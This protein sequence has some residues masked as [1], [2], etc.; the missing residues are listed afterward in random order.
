[1]LGFLAL[2]GALA[3]APPCETGLCSCAGRPDVPS[4]LQSADA[5]FTG[6]VVSVR[7]THPWWRRE[8]DPRRRVTLRVDRAWKGVDSRTV[9]M[10]TRMISTCEFRF[11]RGES[12]LVFAH[13]R[14]DGGLGTSICSRT[15]TIDRA[16]GDVRDLGEPARRFR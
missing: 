11:R 15:T 14:Q 7:N 5:V 8:S 9:V 3:V 13:Q 6:R 4:A 1:M 12:Y 16:A 10:I 2:L